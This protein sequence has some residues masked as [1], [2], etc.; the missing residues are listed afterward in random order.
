MSSVP[1]PSFFV[2]MTGEGEMQTGIM[3]N[4]AKAKEGDIFLS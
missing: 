2:I 1:G 3:T 4:N